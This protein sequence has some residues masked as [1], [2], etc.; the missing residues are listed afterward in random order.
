MAIPCCP[1]CKAP[2]PAEDDPTPSCPYCAGPLERSGDGSGP[3][4]VVLGRKRSSVVVFLLVVN[5]LACLPVALIKGAFAPRG[6]SDGLTVISMGLPIGVALG[7]AA[8]LRWR[9][10]GFHLIVCCYVADVAITIASTQLL[11]GPSLEAVV[12]KCLLVTLGLIY[13][14]ALLKVRPQIWSRLR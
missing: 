9:K 11:Y 4:G 6:Q 5:I 10:W 14:V 1:D 13:V 7:L 12:R 3:R 2:I 8:I